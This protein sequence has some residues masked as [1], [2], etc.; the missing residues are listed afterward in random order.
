MSRL[1]ALVFLLLACDSNSGN[2]MN[3]VP[4]DMTTLP[5]LTTVEVPDMAPD[6][7]VVNKGPKG[8]PGI[9]MMSGGVKASSTNY[10]A[11]FSLGQG[12]GGNNTSS[13]TNTKNKGGLVGATQGR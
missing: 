5:D 1:A 9:S 12:P 6:M 3:T 4:P 13:S 7:T 10:K 8:H 11:V 2:N